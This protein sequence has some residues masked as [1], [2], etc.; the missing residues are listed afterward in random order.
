MMSKKSPLSLT[1]V[2][3][4]SG[5]GGQALGLE[6]AGFDHLQLVEL[7]GSACATLR[8]NRPEWDVHEGDLREYSGAG[9]KGVDLFAGGVP[10]PPFSKAGKQLGADDERDLF[11]EAIRIVDQCR[12]RAVMLENVRGMLDPIFKD[13]RENLVRQLKR[14][15]YH[16][17]WKL[18]QASDFG[19]PQLRPRVIFV[20]TRK[21]ISEHFA[22]P[23][24]SKLPPKTVGESLVDL[25]SANGWTGAASW[26]EGAKAIAPTLVGGSK[27][28]G[29]PDLGPTRAK[30]AWAALGVDGMGIANEPP[31]PDHLGMPK[32]TVRM[33][34]RIQGFPD[35]WTFS[36]KKT[37]AYRQVG[38]AFPPP[39][40]KAVG[41]QIARALNLAASASKKRSAA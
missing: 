22:W 2:E 5:A 20:A 25:M 31:A 30:R 19:V 41:D 36:G 13:Y 7:D 34:A 35:E 23:E 16:A 11:P 17:E 10:C 9:H 12:P 14:L 39:V 28:H 15:G 40:A 26:A 1:S 18:L 32:L 8:L 27:K 3:V 6:M 21:E 4:C 29:G 24:A 38:N 37:S 33:A